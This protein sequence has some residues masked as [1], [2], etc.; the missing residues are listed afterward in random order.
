MPLAPNDLLK[1]FLD[2][3]SEGLTERM[4]LE[5]EAIKKLHIDETVY[6]INKTGNS[7]KN[8][9]KIDNIVDAVAKG[10][11][12][13]TYNIYCIKRPKPGATENSVKQNN[14]QSLIYRID[15]FI[16]TTHDI[17][18]ESNYLNHNGFLKY[19]TE[20]YA[21]NSSDETNIVNELISI[22]KNALYRF[23]MNETHEV[24]D[25]SL[26]T[27]RQYLED[28]Y[29]CYDIITTKEMKL[30]ELMYDID[31]T[32]YDELL[33]CLN[34][35]LNILSRDSNIK[36]P[37]NLMEYVE[38]VKNIELLDNIKNDMSVILTYLKYFYPVYKDLT[39]GSLYSFVDGI[40][41]YINKVREK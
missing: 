11:I 39:K 24:L 40:S 34:S 14:I 26:Y 20:Y 2:G 23:Y 25:I 33:R 37:E 12:Y 13:D 31:I 21:N 41:V 7:S 4:L 9:I 19:L 22:Y 15:E 36:T 32:I 1:L 18:K 10:I 17:N 5:E 8:I 3:V 38:K 28:I 16:S 29:E 6:N 35:I 27:I 30:K